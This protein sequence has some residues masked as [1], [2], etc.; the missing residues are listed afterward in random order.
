MLLASVLLL[1]GCRDYRDIRVTS[2]SIESLSPHGLRS[3]G[4]ALCV[5]VSNPAREIRLSDMEGTVRLGGEALGTFNAEPVVIPAKSFSEVDVDAQV[6]ADASM[7][8]MQAI[9]LFSR[10]DPKECTVDISLTVKIKGGL[11]KRLSFKNVPVM[12]FLR[13]VEYESI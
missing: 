13:K 4:I 12:D 8:F 1:A 6:H 5:G 11:R 2:C 9:S 7:S 3:A 10:L